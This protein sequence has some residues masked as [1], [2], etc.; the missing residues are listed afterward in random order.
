MRKLMVFNSMSL[1]GFIADS[2]GDMSWA[3]KQDDEWNSFVAGN[4]S[5]EGV[6]VFG[7]KT[8]DMMAG[9][10]PTPMAALNSPVV[11]RRMNELHK[12]VFSRT[13]EKP[14]WQNTTLLQGQLTEDVR[15]LK[16]LDGPDL[17]II[18]SASIVAQ[19]SAARLIDE[20][21]IALSPVLLGAGK[22]MFA[23]I[24]EKLALKLASTRSFQNG[25]VFLT[26]H[27]A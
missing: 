8:Y 25:N 5:E 13:M 24:G 18:G 26:Y 22:S 27:R 21:Q 19:L 11:A 7:R 14:S 4:A 15:R 6:L 2:N 23:E 10:W 12:I 9:Y 20:Y 16:Q 17:V 3:H 1:D